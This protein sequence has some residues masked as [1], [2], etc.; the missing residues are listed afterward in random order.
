MGRRFAAATTALTLVALMAPLGDIALANHPAGTCLQVTPETDSNPTGTSHEFTATLSAI[1]GTAPTASCSTIAVNATTDLKISYELSGANDSDG[2]TPDT[3]DGECTITATTSFCKFSILAANSTASGTTTVRAWID[4]DGESPADGGITEADRAEGQA[5]G[6]SPGTG[7]TPPDTPPATEPDC[8]DVVTK[9]WTASRLDCNPEQKDNPTGTTHTVTCTAT[10][11][12]G[13]RVVGTVVD[14]EATGANDPDGGNSGTPDFSCTTIADDATTPDTNEGGTCKF[15]HP[16]TAAL[17]QGVTLYRAWIDDDGNPDN[18]NEGD[19]TEGRDEVATPGTTPEPDDTDVVEKTWKASRLDCTPDTATNKAGETHTV[20]CTARDERGNT[21]SGTKVDYEASGQDD[22]GTTPGGASEDTANGAGTAAAP[23][24]GSCTTGSDGKCT[25]THTSNQPGTSTYRAWIDDDGNDTNINEGDQTEP[26]EPDDTDDTDVMTKTWTTADPA[27]IDCDETPVTGDSERAVNPGSS[28]AESNETYVCSITDTKGNA[29]GGAPVYA[30]VEAPVNDP[31][32]PD[33]ASYTSPDYTCTTGTSGT[34]NSGL[35]KCTITVTQADVEVGT[36]EICFWSGTPAEGGDS[37]HCGNEP[38]D[39]PTEGETQASDETDTG[40]DLADQVEKTWTVATPDEASQIDCAPESDANPQGSS[41]TITCT[42]RTSAGIA[43]Q[44][45]EVD[46]EA[47]GVNDP[48]TTAG[49]SPMSPDFECITGVDGTCSFTHGPGTTEKP[50]TGTTNASGRTTYRAWIDADNLDTTT[51]ADTAEGRDEQTQPGAGCLDPLPDNEPDCTDVVEKVWGA[52]RLD[53]TPETARNPSGTLHTITCTATDE[54]GALIANVNVDAEATGANDPDTVDGDSPDSPD[55]TCT[56]D[57]TGTCQIKH[58][59]T[60]TGTTNSA[61]ETVYRAWIDADKD[62]ATTEADDGEG[63][64]SS[65]SGDESGCAPADLAPGT[66]CTSPVGAEPDC[67]D[68]VTKT[69]TASRVECT[70]ETDTNPTGTRHDITCT[71][72]DAAGD[73]VE[74]TVI[75]AEATGTN[76][77]DSANSPTSPDFTCTTDATGTCQ[78]SHGPGGE[79][80]TDDV[81]TTTYRA[82]IDEDDDDTT[83]EADATE[84]RDEASSAGATAEPDDTDVVEKSWNPS[85]LEC[86]PETDGNPAGTSHTIQ[87]SARNASNQPEA[88]IQ[89]D[90]EATGANDP[91]SSNTPLTPDFTCTT[92]VDGKCTFTHG[93]GGKGTTNTIGTTTYRAWRD[94]DGSDTTTEADTT[95]GR[96]E[97]ANPGSVPESDETDVVAKSWGASF[98]DCS[99][100]TST[101]SAG[102]VHTITC[103]T[104][105]SGNTVA[106]TQVDVEATG[107]NDPDNGNTPATPDFTCTTANNGTCTITHTGQGAGETTYR[108]WIDSDGSNSTPEADATE[109]R[110]EQATPGAT[111]E[112]DTTD[113]VTRTWTAS[114]LECEP[115]TATNNVGTSHTITCTATSAS[116]TLAPNIAIDVEVTGANDPDSGNTRTTPDFSCTTS[117]AGTC[118]FTHGPTNTGS[119]GESTYRAWIDADGNNAN[120]EADAA[121]GPNE[122]SDPGA[123]E[124]DST[125]VVTKTWVEESA[126]CN[127]GVDNDDDGDIDYPEDSGCTSTSD[128]DETETAAGCGRAAQS[129]ENV[130]IGT[131]GADVLTGTNGRD[132]ICGLGGEDVIDGRGGRDRIFGDAGADVAGGGDGNDKVVGG[133]GNDNVSGNQGAD[134]VKGGAADDSIKGNAGVDRLRGGNG[135]DSLQGGNGDDNLSG[136]GGDDTLRGGKGR[137]RLDGGNGSDQCFGNGNEDRRTRCE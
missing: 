30:E 87:C 66:S 84:G 57:S 23:N 70:P 74:G 49:N 77:P 124:T 95:E 25:F 59:P 28:G 131:D 135:N 86:E 15:N 89:I 20:T 129:G 100:E 98:L 22:P 72:T 2:N 112:S 38:T 93:P 5:E 40:N 101:G 104:R 106:G 114:R 136:G 21:V 134:L 54:T 39:G 75:D 19:L 96:D 27:T 116:N 121:E 41:H 79:G 11:A 51:E 14:A 85:P 73:P 12:A 55:F 6:T 105:H 26:A 18:I 16:G 10:D 133:A 24:D 13:S 68:V 69:W 42:V 62:N 92:G 109:G 117:S 43:V 127:D 130:I 115:E 137:D 65:T 80:T 56:T 125:D 31:D 81:G 44:G 37:A 122:A 88:G 61:G 45:A 64:C 90:V 17:D 126:D 123:A 71:A 76:D 9:T 48:D 34:G 83:T 78:I 107:A 36:T 52:S 50:G 118:S 32:E 97:S 120:A 53:C 108:A 110:D 33:S 47:T 113:V 132:L 94:E 35:G 46:V 1:S 67:T 60:G 102:S 7:C 119:S 128:D 3:P 4:H 8:T 58:G 82:W 103:T 111:G 99:P 29:V 63:P 91:D